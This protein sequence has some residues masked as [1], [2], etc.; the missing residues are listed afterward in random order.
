VYE[1][2]EYEWVFVANI[3]VGPDEERYAAEA[4]SD[5]RLGPPFVL[6]VIARAERP[7]RSHQP[8]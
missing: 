1:L 4:K 7:S 8:R 2:W 6:F 5:G 3:V